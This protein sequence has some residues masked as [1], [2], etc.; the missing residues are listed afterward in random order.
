MFLGFIVL[1]LFCIFNLCCMKRYFP[2][3]MFCTFTLI[4]CEV[5]VQCPVWLVFFSCSFFILCFSAMFLRYFLNYFEVV[6]FAPVTA[7]ITFVC[8][9]PCVVFLL[10]GLNI[11]RS[12]QLLSLSHFCLLF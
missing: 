12:S 11:V 2:C 4:L 5:C 9:F 6:P 1:H 7:G 8:T 10:W 3:Q